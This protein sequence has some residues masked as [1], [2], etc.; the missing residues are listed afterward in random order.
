LFFLAS[1]LTWC[2][3]L[4][5][6]VTNYETPP[7]LNSLLMYGN[8]IRESDQITKCITILDVEN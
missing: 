6:L 5:F 2:L 8:V 4:N 7:M 3:F 1:T